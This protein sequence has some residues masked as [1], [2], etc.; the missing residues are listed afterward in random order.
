MS[1]CVF[2][3]IVAGRLASY[4]VLED[5]YAVAFLDI[6]PAAPGHTL[7]VPREHAA[8]IWSIS[9]TVHAHVARMVHR[10]AALVKAALA[11]DGVNVVHSTGEAAGQEVFHFHT[12]VVPRRHGDDLRPMWSSQPA[13]GHELE[14][15]LARIAAAR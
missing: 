4:R 10:V 7:V 8:D 6:A 9:E 1:E 13:S 5:E 3:G 2:C 14:R 12:H 15:T 11:P